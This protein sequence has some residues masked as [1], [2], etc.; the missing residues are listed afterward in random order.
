MSATAEEEITLGGADVVR[1]FT[2]DLPV[3]PLRGVLELPGGFAFRGRA[4]EAIMRFDPLY[5]SNYPDFL[6]QGYLFY[7]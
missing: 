1:A 3:R 7:R 4:P 5:P 2:M 6:G